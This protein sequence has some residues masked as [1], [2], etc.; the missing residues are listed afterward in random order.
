METELTERIGANL[1]ILYYEQESVFFSA[2]EDDSDV[3]G[4]S[5]KTKYFDS[6]LA[7]SYRISRKWSTSL[8]LGYR[9]RERDESVNS[10]ETNDA[11]AYKLGASVVYRFKDL[12]R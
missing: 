7:F 4:S 11:S 3:G 1:K 12:K 2:D 6:Q 9:Q 5:R 10:S 8:R